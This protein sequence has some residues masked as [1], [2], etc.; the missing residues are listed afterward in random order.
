[1][2]QDFIGDGYEIEGYIAPLERLGVGEWKF[3]YRPL[4]GGK[5]ERLLALID[6]S[7]PA[8]HMYAEAAYDDSVK[9]L[10]KQ[11]V[12]W[13]KPVPVTEENIRRMQPNAFRIVR[14]IVL[15]LRPSD[16]RPEGEAPQPTSL[17]EG[18]DAKN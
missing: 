3:T 14:N 13:E 16:P 4:V 9:M 15:G 1:M 5:R 10:A 2:L 12:K 11:I 18:A 17:T 6:E 8:A 7:N